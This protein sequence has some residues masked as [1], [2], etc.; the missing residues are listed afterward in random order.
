MFSVYSKDGLAT[1]SN[2]Y[3]IKLVY[4]FCSNSY[5]YFDGITRHGYNQI[6]LHCLL[7]IT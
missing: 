4:H 1:K 7:N 5:L 6:W 3:H 2:T